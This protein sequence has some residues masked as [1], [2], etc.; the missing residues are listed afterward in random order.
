MYL[1]IVE[2]PTKAKTIQRYLGKSFAVRATYGH[3]KDLPVRGLGVDEETLEAE[4]V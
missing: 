3:I 4:Y 1:F 2:S